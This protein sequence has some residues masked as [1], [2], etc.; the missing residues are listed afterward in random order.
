[1][2]TP[3]STHC[4][5]FPSSSMSSNQSVIFSNRFLVNTVSFKSQTHFLQQISVHTQQQ[6]G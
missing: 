2:A 5:S 6:D 1:M 4:R 3:Y